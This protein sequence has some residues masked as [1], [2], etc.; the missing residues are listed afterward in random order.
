[1]EVHQ[2]C[3]ANSDTAKEVTPPL[4]DIS[5]T[6]D[7]PNVFN[8]S[9]MGKSYKF[10][11]MPC[12]ENPQRTHEEQVWLGVYSG[13]SKLT[14]VYVNLKGQPIYLSFMTV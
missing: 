2:K 13:G 1:M 14:N 5:Q 11:S 7:Q 10:N 9:L 3:C 6:C 12:I 4:T 8:I